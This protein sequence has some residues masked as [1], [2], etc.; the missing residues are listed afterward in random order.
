[1]TLFLNAVE[2]I[3]QF[4]LSTIYDYRNGHPLIKRMYDGRSAFPLMELTLLL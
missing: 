3:R 2:Y 1:M 4:L